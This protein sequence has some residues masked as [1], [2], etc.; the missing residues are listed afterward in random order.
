[1]H[2]QHSII[3]SAYLSG[4]INNNSPKVASLAKPLF[5]MLHD[6]Q[7]FICKI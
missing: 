3:P 1:M 6:T 2:H 7:A 4:K 5:Q